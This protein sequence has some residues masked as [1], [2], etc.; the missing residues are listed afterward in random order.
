MAESTSGGHST[1][2][3]RASL[4]LRFSLLPVVAAPLPGCWAS[5]NCSCGAQAFGS[6][7][8]CAHAAPMLHTRPTEAPTTVACQRRAAS[9]DLRF[10]IRSPRPDN[11]RNPG[12]FLGHDPE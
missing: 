9:V 2:S 7:R 3:V 10:V 5:P 8:F 12:R 1:P 4:L 11:G 6:T